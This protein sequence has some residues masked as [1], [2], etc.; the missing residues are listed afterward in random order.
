[1]NCNRI[2]GLKYSILEQ[3]GY[4]KKLH[5]GWVKIGGF[6]VDLHT[7]AKL[8][9]QR[10]MNKEGVQWRRSCIP[11]F[12]RELLLTDFFPLGKKIQTLT[13]FT[14]LPFF[15]TST[16]YLF[17]SWTLMG[18]SRIKF[19]KGWHQLGHGELWYSKGMPLDRGM[20]T[21]N[22]AQGKFHVCWFNNSW[23]DRTNVL[24]WLRASP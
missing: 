15:L 3:A 8:R 19:K 23:K 4:R 24:F 13:A 5:E 7:S 14:G 17:H 12:I 1:M 20:T 21:S 6:I 10:G 16:P 2:I 18:T 22:T 11:L 9:G